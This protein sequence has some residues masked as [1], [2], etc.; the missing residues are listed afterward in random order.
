M[1]S[2]NS[3]KPPTTTEVAAHLRTK[4]DWQTLD[5]GKNKARL[6]KNH[7]VFSS[8]F[9]MFHAAQTHEEREEARNKTAEALL[10]EFQTQVRRKCND[11]LR[12][13]TSFSNPA[14]AADLSDFCEDLAQSLAYNTIEHLEKGHFANVGS[15]LGY[16]GASIKRV[17]DRCRKRIQK[18]EKHG[19]LFEEVKDQDSDDDKT[20][21]VIE[22]SLGKTAEVDGYSRSLIRSD[23]PDLCQLIVKASLGPKNQKLIDAYELGE[24][25]SK[26]SALRLGIRPNTF[27][28]RMKRLREALKPLELEL[29]L[30]HQFGVPAGYTKRMAEAILPLIVHLVHKRKCDFPVTWNAAVSLGQADT[31]IEPDE[32]AP[33]SGWIAAVRCLFRLWCLEH[34]PYPPVSL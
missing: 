11:V 31:A 33:K 28:Q 13:S 30:A 7:L 26:P 1:F 4:A 20:E 29:Y 22:T 24:M 27:D 9:Q 2:T 8:V 17:P 18:L 3:D 19:I 5:R 14:V 34:H 21:E 10:I 12:Q 32:K 25:A 23:G 6:I 15:L 16:I